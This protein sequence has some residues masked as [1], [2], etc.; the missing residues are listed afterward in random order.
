MEPPL[1]SSIRFTAVRNSFRQKAFRPVCFVFCCLRSLLQDPEQIPV[2]CR[3]FSLAI[4]IKLKITEL[5]CAPAGVL[6]KVRVIYRLQPYSDSLN[7]IFILFDVYR[8]CNTLEIRFV[9][10]IGAIT[11]VI[12][13]VSGRAI[14][15]IF[16]FAVNKCALICFQLNIF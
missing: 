1:K 14:S 13:K 2:G 11:T 4:S 6:A 12:Q 5:N 3:P 10:F 7:P 9:I 15:S 8:E 16:Y